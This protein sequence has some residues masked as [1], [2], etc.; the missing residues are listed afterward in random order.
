MLIVFVL[1]EAV[2]PGWAALAT[3]LDLAR[4]F[5]G[6]EG[7]FVLFDEQAQ[8]YSRYNPE[9]CAE[10]YSPCSTFKIPNS[11]IALDT[12]VASGPDFALKWDGVT[13]WAPA[14][15]KDQTLSSAF[16]NSVVWFYQEMASRVGAER[17]SNYVKKLDYGNCDISGGITDF[18][19][20]STLKVSADEQVKLL[21]RLWAGSL[22]VS[23]RAQSITRELMLLSRDAQGR[24]LYGKTGTGGDV[25][26]D[27][28]RLGWFV[29]CLDTGKR[30]YFFAGRMTG[31]PNASG[32]AVRRMMEK[33]FTDLGI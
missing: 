3:N 29:G 6:R 24:S 32:R 26:A 27:I 21:R 19:L 15:N 25:K 14:W 2:E 7:C 22:P 16:S 4:Y 8:V 28:A 33:I 11:L 23:Q 13:R 17:M 31:P 10:R 18:W 12:G 5:G 1:L 30:R 20:E 9:G